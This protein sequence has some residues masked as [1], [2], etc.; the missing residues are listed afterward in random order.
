MRMPV[1]LLEGTVHG[2]R[3]AA[4]QLAA[5]PLHQSLPLLSW[6]AP[7]TM[8][9]GVTTKCRAAHVESNLW[10]L[11]KQW[12]ASTR[13]PSG[14]EEREAAVPPQHRQCLQAV[15][16][17]YAGVAAAQL[18]ACKAL[19]GM[20]VENNGRRQEAGRLGMLADVQ[21][22]MRGAPHSGQAKR[23]GDGVLGLSA[24]W[25]FKTTQTKPGP[26][27]RAKQTHAGEPGLLEDIQ[28][29]MCAHS[30]N[31]S[32][33]EEACRGGW[34]PS[35]A[36]ANAAAGAAR[37]I[38]LL[39]AMRTHPGRVELQMEACTARRFAAVASLTAD[40]GANRSNAVL[41][42]ALA[43]IQQ[44]MVHRTA[45]APGSWSTPA[46][47]SGPSARWQIQAAM[48]NH[49]GG[50]GGAAA[51]QHVCYALRVLVADGSGAAAGGP[52]GGAGGPSSCDAQPTGERR[53][54][55]G[56]LAAPPEPDRHHGGQS[57]GPGA[58]PP[59]GRAE[60]ARPVLPG[61]GAV[62][63][64][65]AAAVRGMSGGDIA[66]MEGPAEADAGQSSAKLHLRLGMGSASQSLAAAALTLAEP[67]KC[68]G[69]GGCL[70][71]SFSIHSGRPS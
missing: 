46:A 51:M 40:H 30:S 65:V 61:S 50:H 39:L 27:S 6:S 31:A 33:Q 66:V 37:G 42:G 25:R 11:R 58:A 14:P 18:E 56:A 68:T 35:C 5:M 16:K 15:M 7:S 2:S 53:H 47:R 9:S 64:R 22:A 70:H 60:G 43:D 17:A 62:Q 4:A 36:A 20:V 45:A 71:A 67:A 57:R 52:P 41:L 69:G 63:A 8:L 13:Q 24:A 26:G 34:R 1:N 3:D 55:A 54:P 48:R 49:S 38:G 23:A 19:A 59:A 10:E 32:V 29:A 12:W 21:R 44:S 28:R